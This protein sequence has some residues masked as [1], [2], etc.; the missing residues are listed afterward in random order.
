[1]YWLHCPQ[2]CL[3]NLGERLANHELEVVH[4]TDTC[5][6]CTV[7]ESKYEINIIPN[8]YYANLSVSAKPGSV[9]KPEDICQ[10]SDPK[11]LSLVKQ[12]SSLGIEPIMPRIDN[13][14]SFIESKFTDC[15]LVKMIG[16]A[17]Y[18]HEKV[19]ELIKSQNFEEAST[20]KKK[21]DEFRDRIALICIERD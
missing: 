18:H 20:H 1:M 4:E 5:F 14:L 11:L 10:A 2:R 21:R 17:R 8:E 7:G 12:L 13:E 15:S 16:E 3:V 9:R 19:K 6:V